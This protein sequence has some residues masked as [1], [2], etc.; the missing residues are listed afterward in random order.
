MYNEGPYIRPLHRGHRNWARG[1]CKVNILYVDLKYWYVVPSRAIATHDVH[2]FPT[3]ISRHH[4][5][6]IL[7]RARMQ[8]TDTFFGHPPVNE[9]VP[10]L[11][12]LEIRNG[13]YLESKSFRH[14]VEVSCTI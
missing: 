2:D 8:P 14:P 6:D 13:V 4:G 9:A 3:H 11:L 7:I 5:L 12:F 1:S 10:I